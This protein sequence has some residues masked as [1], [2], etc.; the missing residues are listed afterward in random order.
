MFKHF[1]FLL[2]KVSKNLFFQLLGLWFWSSG[3]DLDVQVCGA[4][5]KDAHFC[6]WHPCACLQGV[7]EVFAHALSVVFSRG[8][9]KA[10][11]QERPD[12]SIPVT[13]KLDQ[14]LI[15]FLGVTKVS[16]SIKPREEH[17]KGWSGSRVLS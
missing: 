1:H 3:Q 2:L 9:A 10:Q 8:A 17:R 14:G 15:D 11:G 4:A 13:K 5:R 7:A 12:G 6:A 16:V